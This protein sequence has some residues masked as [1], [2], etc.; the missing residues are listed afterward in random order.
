MI[1]APEAN[2]MD[3]LDRMLGHDYWATNLLLETCAPLTEAQL[4]Q[5]FDVG[6]KTILATLT[7]QIHVLNY[8]RQGMAGEQMTKDWPK[9]Q[10]IAELIDVHNRYQPA[11]AQIARSAQANDRLDETFTDFY[12][13][14]QS[15]GATILQ[16]MYH[17]TWHR[18]EVRHML[19]RLGIA[20]VWDGDPQEWEYV[21]RNQ[22]PS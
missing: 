20:D 3:L 19:Q 5:E 6:N 7:H 15:I 4:T 21:L 9:R 14:P 12:G 17:N 8:W 18:S 22:N 13:Y 10:S 2:A 1:P 16:T 11:F